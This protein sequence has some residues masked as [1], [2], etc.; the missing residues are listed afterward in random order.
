MKKTFACFAC[1]FLFFFSAAAEQYRIA[2]V[3][4]NSKEKTDPKMLMRKIPPVEKNRLFASKE[5]L[6]E[7]LAYICQQLV[8]TRLLE[9]IEYS[10]E[11]SGVADSGVQL[12]NVTYSFED[13][14]SFMIVPYPTY[15]SNTGLQFTV[16]AND[17]NFLGKTN[18]FKFFVNCTFGTE[19]EPDNFSKITPGFGVEYSFPFDVG[20]VV[21]SWNSLVALAWTIGDSMPEFGVVTGPSLA[22]PIGKQQLNLAFQQSAIGKKDFKKYD[23][24]PY[25]A[26]RVK[27]SLP[28]TIAKIG[29]ATPLVYQPYADLHYNWDVNRIADENNR[30]SA[31]PKLTLG[32]T[33]R[34]NGVDWLGNFRNGYSFSTTQ[35]ISKSFRDGEMSSG[36]IP[37]VD[38]DIKLFKGWKYAGLA[39]NLHFFTMFKADGNKDESQLVNI[40]PRLRGALDKQVF[41]TSNGYASIDDYNLA[42][43]TDQAVI[44]SLEA[45]FHLITTNF[46]GFLS[47]INAELQLSPFVD[48]ALLKN[49]ARKV[50]D[51]ENSQGSIFSVKDG[52]Y[53]AGIEG[54][55]YPTKF[56]SYVLH[57]SIGF[58]VGKYIIKDYNGDWR[59]AEKGWEISVGFGH[60]F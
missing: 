42:L 51:S 14:K 44:L 24:N 55:I 22:I 57:A 38:C 54:F 17:Q 45:P 7:Y 41:D 3:T 58:D 32:Q 39:A 34:V 60:H 52:I 26:E 5:E 29:T 4:F 20:P 1:L 19:E 37:Y 33:T 8:N 46:G 53:C 6:E 27:I 47:S 13:S 30:L 11:P 35:A 48:M 56:K 2:D 28:L 59:K 16:M 36:I 18:P 12:V 9:N 10:W 23:D 50:G 43:E 49:R 21:A 25:F 15:S 40:G 31:T